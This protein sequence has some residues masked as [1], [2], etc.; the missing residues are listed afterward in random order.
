MRRGR[1]WIKFVEE[2]RVMRAVILFNQDSKLLP[3]HR[4]PFFGTKAI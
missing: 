1:R 4:T 3:G 2:R